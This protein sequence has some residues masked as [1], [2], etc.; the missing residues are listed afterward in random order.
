MVTMDSNKRAGAGLGTNELVDGRYKIVKVVG[1]GG[2]GTV[3]LAEHTLI[4]R[5]VAV[6]VL[7][8]ELASDRSVVERFLNEARAAGTLGHANIVE[9]TD[10][11]FLDQHDGKGRV[12]YIVFEYLEGALLTEE[13]HRLGALSPRRAANIARQIASALQAAHAAGIIHR[14]LKSDNVY[15]TER[16]DV[17]DHVK[18]LD[19]GISKF[20]EHSSDERTRRGMLM[21]TPEFMAPEQITDPDH[22]DARV[23]VYALG[24]ILYEML[25]GR[26]PFQGDDPRTLLHRIVHSEAPPIDRPEVPRALFDILDRMLAKHPAD[27]FQ[28]MDEAEAALTQHITSIEVGVRRT[29]GIPVQ[30]M[31][32]AV[33][34]QPWSGSPPVNTPWPVVAS[35]VS[36][37]TPPKGRSP[38]LLY[39][40]VGAGVLIGAVGLFVGMRHGQ[41]AAPATTPMAA[42]SI[43]RS[44]EPAPASKIKV[45]F[46][47]ATPGAKVTFRRRI[48][49]APSAVDV[50]AT[51]IVEL[52][53][54][55]APGH[56]TVRYWLTIDRPTTLTA[57]L[58]PGNGFVEA[59]E[60]E[61]LVALGEAEAE[62]VAIAAAAPSTHASA[63]P[64]VAAKAPASAVA[65]NRIAAVGPARASVVAPARAA[66][67]AVAAAPVVTPR[68]IGKAAAEADAV[69]VASGPRTNRITSA[70]QPPPAPA[71][72]A[73][74]MATVETPAPVAP[75][76]AR[77]PAR[78]A[79]PTPAIA[80]AV[81]VE[82]AAPTATK[83]VAP[84]SVANLSID[85]GHLGA[86]VGKHRGEVL[87][88]LAAGKKDNKALKGAVTVAMQ[89][90]AS[91]RVV[92]PQINSTLKGA[93][94]VS[95]CVL[96]SVASWKFPARPGQPAASASYTFTLN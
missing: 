29:R 30:T 18:V 60:A 70:D 75:P 19:F 81:P 48:T 32:D 59:S 64:A 52:V 95:A 96:K 13:V 7:H 83:P 72:V 33:G 10:M 36:L 65:P 14:D 6:K 1:E 80:K 46:Q 26:R 76:V 78:E 87:G 82:T 43:P 88:C 3:Y 92:R 37:P 23:D 90:D 42:A 94:T 85:R 35:S 67:P 61:T 54:V 68:K 17:V 12:P 15:L 49:A 58:P 31:S 91:G 66:A 45:Q 77:E 63:L 11:G 40:M 89:V 27:R 57:T 50:V 62:P 21:G 39:G 55:S 24:V 53:E 79:V 41:K 44:D 2:M 38:A 5:R 73:P 4:R 56:K 51:D 93:P 20:M 34:N 22:I 69:A 28:S 84:T 47:S 74:T 16:G 9:S 86:V 25:A 71:P 8:P